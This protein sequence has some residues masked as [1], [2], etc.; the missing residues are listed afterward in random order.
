MQDYELIDVITRSRGVILDIL[1]KRGYQTNAFRKFSPKEIR[2]MKE[3][4]EKEKDGGALRMD[5]PGPIEG[6]TCRVIYGL[7]KIKQKLNTIIP[8]LMDAEKI[9]YADP[10]TTEIVFMLVE[11]LADSFHKVAY[12]VYMSNRLR[13]WFYQMKTIISDPTKHYLV[14]KHEKVTT[15][16]Y[17]KLKDEKCIRVKTQLPLIR[18]HFDIQARIL[19]LVPGDVVRITRQS[20][21]VGEAIIYRVCAA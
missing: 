20:D 14:P 6:H 3:S 11:P 8:S 21:S 13:I 4:D 7:N 9:S 16:E 2:L 18:F 10:E 1:E 15:D 5:I 19:G 12:D 17:E